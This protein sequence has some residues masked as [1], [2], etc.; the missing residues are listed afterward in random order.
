M[1][2]KNLFVVVLSCVL[3]LACTQEN[4]PFAIDTD[5]MEVGS[6]GGVRT[7]NISADDR[8]VVVV[9]TAWVTVS[10]ANGIG[11]TECRVSIDSSIVF[12]DRKANIMLLPQ[13]GR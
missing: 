6:C 5:R 11:S 9:D 8:W 1:N 12:R 4:I 7:L 3:C 2:I 13:K 10:P